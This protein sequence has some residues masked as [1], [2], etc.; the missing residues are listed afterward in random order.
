MK[1]WISRWSLIAMVLALL[2]GAP[3]VTRA[4]TWIV[5]VESND[6]DPFDITI[7]PGDD[8]C[9]M[10]TT[11][12]HT[13]TSVDGLWDSDV[14]PPGSMFDYTFTDP[15]DYYYICTLHFD[16]CGMAG[17]VHVVPPCCCP[18]E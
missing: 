2:L 6:F 10:W 14:L 16:C 13:T 5:I 1:S 9:W 4:D 11:G 15:G 12:F 17:V 18:K 8:V 7:A 3:A